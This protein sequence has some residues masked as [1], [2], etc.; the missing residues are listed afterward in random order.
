MKRNQGIALVTVMMVTGLLMMLLASFVRIN[1][2]HF[3]ILKND[4]S[5]TAATQA[6]YS[7][8]D[9]CSFRLE[10]DRSWGAKRF[11]GHKD[12]RLQGFLN[13]TEVD[14][15]FRVEGK[16]VESHAEF[17]AVVTNNIDGA[18]A[19]DGV[20]QGQC[21]ILITA[22][23]GTSVV[24]SEAI[25]DTAP[26]FDASVI[27]SEDIKIDATSLIVSS[28]D[29]FRNRLRAKEK[30]TVPDFRNKE[31][32]FG[33]A[34]NATERGVLWAQDG[35]NMGGKS[36]NDPTV[37]QAA[38][39]ATK[40]QFFPNAT[41]QYDV[42]DLQLN[43]V[44]SSQNSVSVNSGIYVFNDQR[45]V[46]YKD[47]NGE[48]HKIR[49]PMLERRDWAINSNGDMDPDR[50]KVREVW[51]L[52]AHLPKNSSSDWVRSLGDIPQKNLHP[53]PEGE[54]TFQ[55]DKG[56]QVHFNSLD[57]NYRA[58]GKT[59]RPPEIV[60]NSNVNLSV[61]G[62]FGVAS[63]DPKHRPTVIFRDP[64]TGEV[65]QDNKGEIVSGSITTRKHGNK[66]G[67]IYLEGRIEGNGKL[68][69]EGNVTILNT[70]AAI[71]SDELSGLSIY[72]GGTVK[73]KPQRARRLDSSEFHQEALVLGD[74]AREQGTTVFRGLVFAQGDVIIEANI[75]SNEGND[76]DPVDVT[77]EGAVVARKGSVKV[78][79][80]DHVKFVYNP[81]YLDSILDPN[82][83]TTRVRLERVVWKES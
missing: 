82:K 40:G 67:S 26:L 10:S 43:E 18:A 23:Q 70:L 72:S 83:S 39:K 37:A 17:E 52:A 55:L 71:R 34:K 9:Y 7:V 15:T 13:L 48:T 68:L 78:K 80:A 25:L 11:D 24:R 56:V 81:K 31:F 64:E 19:R 49:I 46:E 30:I 79:N 57:P 2:H 36:L 44:K 54:N 5:H 53:I 22:R 74:R 35:I 28:T 77:I 61:D 21:R 60:L 63:S 62:D 14:G 38:V 66:P 20:P 8:Y 32:K 59:T 50:A 41:T 4:Q 3:G 58:K 6:A 47:E 1:Q 65:G 42:Y 27:S 75:G 76:F 12:G 33:P 29:P 16:V 73:I 51:Y 69:A 45:R